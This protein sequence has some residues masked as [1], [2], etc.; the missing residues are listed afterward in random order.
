M[1]KLPREAKLLGLCQVLK[2][3]LY[4]I[5]DNQQSIGG[6]LSKMKELRREYLKL[7]REDFVSGLL[8]TDGDGAIGSNLSRE[9]LTVLMEKI[10]SSFRAD[11]DKAYQILEQE[12]WQK[13]LGE[14]SQQALHRGFKEIS[15]LKTELN[16]VTQERDTLATNKQKLQKETKQLDT[17]CKA[18]QEEKQV[19]QSKV[20]QLTEEVKKLKK[21]QEATQDY[22]NMIKEIRKGIEDKKELDLWRLKI[23]YNRVAALTNSSWSCPGVPQA[24]PFSPKSKFVQK[25]L[26]SL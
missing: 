8:Q 2:A 20:Q 14:M 10:L 13:L 23:F 21:F 5:E 7:L 19:L 18:L 16:T 4:T 25:F 22:Q 17:Q 11:Q 15:I 9:R 12:V 6:V 1:R 3:F 24:Q 26:E